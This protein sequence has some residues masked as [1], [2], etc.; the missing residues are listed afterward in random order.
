MGLPLTETTFADRFQ[1]LGYAT[2]A[3]GKWH[4]GVKPEYR[5]MQRGYDEYF[6]T[7]ANTPYYHPTNFV[8]S[9]S[10]PTRSR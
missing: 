7:L 9:R 1:Q 2:C 4:L 6:G 5:P 10:R 3:I 8:D